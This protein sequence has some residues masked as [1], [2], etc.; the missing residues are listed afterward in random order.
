MAKS[1]LI[2][3]DESVK[4]YVKKLYRENGRTM[5]FWMDYIVKD[6]MEKPEEEKKE[7]FE[8]LKKQRS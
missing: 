7:F 1:T 2:R 6:F 4:G 5:R 3:V 8:N